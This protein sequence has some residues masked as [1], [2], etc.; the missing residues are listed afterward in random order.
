MLLP[1]VLV[2]VN[3]LSV[4]CLPFAVLR[5]VSGLPVVLPAVCRAAVSL[6]LCSHCSMRAPFCH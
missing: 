2:M 4:S 5:L 6:L 3:G 1:P